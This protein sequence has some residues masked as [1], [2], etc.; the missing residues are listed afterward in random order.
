MYF[1]LKYTLYARLLDIYSRSRI[2]EKSRLLC[3]TYRGHARGAWNPAFKQDF[4]Q[5]TPRNCLKFLFT[6]SLPSMLDA[7]L[8]FHAITQLFSSNSCFHALKYESHHAFP[9]GAPLYLPHTLIIW[10]NMFISP[11]SSYNQ[12]KAEPVAVIFRGWKRKRN[13]AVLFKKSKKAARF[14]LNC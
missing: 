8:I 4:A 12:Q 3:N 14:V 9:L 10:H 13:F 5:I 6:P 11:G 7:R 2:A 1:A